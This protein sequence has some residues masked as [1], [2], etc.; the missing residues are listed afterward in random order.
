LLFVLVRH[1]NQWQQENTLRVNTRCKVDDL[2][3]VLNTSMKECAISSIKLGLTK[4]LFPGDRFIFNKS[5]GRSLD[6]REE[7]ILLGSYNSTL[8]YKYDSSSQVS[9][10][11]THLMKTGNNYAWYLVPNDIEGLSISSSSSSSSTSSS[12]PSSS[13]N[14]KRAMDNELY[15][16]LCN[17]ILLPRI[18]NYSGGFVKIFHESGAV[19]RNGLEIDTS[20]VI[21]SIPSNTIV[22]S[23]ESRV[24]A[25]NINRFLVF[26]EGLPLFL[27]FALFSL[28]IFLMI[29]LFSCFYLWFR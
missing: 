4:P 14:H 27:P 11:S 5:S 2:T 20:E 9:V 1:Y 17:S 25:S 18:G 22:Y 16:S 24:N 21:S 29:V 23:L 8:W 7:A 3:V 12:P 28:V 10:T 15:L 13:S 19:M 6:M 26:Y